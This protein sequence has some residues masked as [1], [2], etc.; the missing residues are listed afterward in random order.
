MR[1]TE[2]FI[3]ACAYTANV[4]QPQ[5]NDLNIDSSVYCVVYRY[6]EENNR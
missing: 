2:S 4:F 6:I 1:T 5:T 3:Y